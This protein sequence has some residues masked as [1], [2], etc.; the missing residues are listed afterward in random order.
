MLLLL[1]LELLLAATFGSVLDDCR[2]FLLC[3]HLGLRMFGRLAEDVFETGFNGILFFFTGITVKQT[4][5][6]NYIFNSI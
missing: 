5:R 1:L 3:I 2:I 6:L 4:C